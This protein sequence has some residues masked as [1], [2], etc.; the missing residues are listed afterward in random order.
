M[1]K[2]LPLFLVIITFYNAAAQVTAIPDAAFEQALINEGVDSDGVI[3]GQ[4]LT[5]D[6]LVVTALSITSPDGPSTFIS[7]LAGI[8]AFTNLESLS[9]HFTMCETLNVS[10]LVHLKHLECGDN[11]LTALDVSNNP[12]L[13]YLEMSSGG[14]VLPFNGFTEIDLSHNP[15]ISELAAWGGLSHIDLRNG[16]NNPDMHIKISITPWEGTEPNTMYTTCIEVDDAAAAQNNEFPYSDWTIWYSSSIQT[17][18]LVASCLAA[19]ESINRKLVSLYPNPASG[20]LHIDAPGGSIIDK[21][22]LFD[23]SGRAVREYNTVTAEGIS[24][25]GLQKGMYVIKI[26]SG[27]TIQAEKIV[28]E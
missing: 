25:A 13:E 27:E 8:E 5:A 22:V 26:V 16:N 20:I 10:T 3:N 14:D 6:A 1:K 11:M 7:N 12:E 9:V 2:I 23:I 4:L 18:A 19:T 28:V 15:N 21:A 17:Y 24:V